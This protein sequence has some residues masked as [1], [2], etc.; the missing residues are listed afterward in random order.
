MT[1]NLKPISLE[2][3]LGYFE[4]DGAR[5]RLLALLERSD[6]THVVLCE[7][8]EVYSGP[9]GNLETAV[10]VGPGC[11]WK[12]PADACRVGDVPSRFHYPTRVYAKPETA[13]P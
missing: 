1:L 7:D 2:D 6:V 8:L 12:T 13:S 4:G 3:L 9:K 5:A 11:T 10:I